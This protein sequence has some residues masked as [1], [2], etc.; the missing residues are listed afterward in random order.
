MREGDKSKDKNKN[1]RR[2]KRGEMRMREGCDV[3]QRWD[4]KVAKEEVQVRKGKR[5]RVDEGRR[6]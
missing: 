6:G 1:G 2:R 3:V 4:R 5:K